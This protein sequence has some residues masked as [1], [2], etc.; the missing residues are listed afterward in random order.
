MGKFGKR[1][2]TDE[3]LQMNLDAFLKAVARRRPESVKGRYLT[4]AMVK[5][6]MGPTLKVDLSLY[7]TIGAANH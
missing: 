1:D 3:N 7:Q 4:N 6:S 5:T 2:F